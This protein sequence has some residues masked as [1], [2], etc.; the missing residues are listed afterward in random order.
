MLA[1]K[2]KE[3]RMMQLVDTMHAG[4][5]PHPNVMRVL[6]IVDGGSDNLQFTKRDIQNKF[7]LFVW[8]LLYA[9]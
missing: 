8:L 1:H 9:K 3:P 7:V 5:V 6:R 2:V 4:H